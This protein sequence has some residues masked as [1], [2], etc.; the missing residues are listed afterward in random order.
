MGNIQK[1][2]GER[3]NVRTEQSTVTEQVT[4]AKTNQRTYQTLIEETERNLRKQQHDIQRLEQRIETLREELSAPFNKTLTDEEIAQLDS[5]GDGIEIA[6]EKLQAASR[7]KMQIQGE[8]TA[9]ENELN[10]NLLKQQDDLSKQLA[11]MNDD[12]L[13]EN[14]TDCYC[15]L[16]K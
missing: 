11:D 9:L 4:S 12:E 14:V 15:F 8:T 1:V 13:A 6:R 7:E 2:E 16:L 5:L 10:E 3:S